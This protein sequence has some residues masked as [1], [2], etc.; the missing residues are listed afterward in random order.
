MA[1]AGQNRKSRT[2]ILMSV[3]PP[4]AEVA[5]HGAD[6]RYVPLA[7]VAIHGADVRYVP[8][9]EM[10]LAASMGLFP[11]LKKERAPD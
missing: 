3:K 2:T 7:E 9:A 1:A 11:K 8:K 4:R 5:I 6:V 10:G